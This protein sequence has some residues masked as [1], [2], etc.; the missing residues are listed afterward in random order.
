MKMEILANNKAWW[1][2][3][4]FHVVEDVFRNEASARTGILGVVGN[5][6]EHVR[7]ASHPGSKQQ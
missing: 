2:E 6:E 4:L 7:K 1:I 3:L 5:P